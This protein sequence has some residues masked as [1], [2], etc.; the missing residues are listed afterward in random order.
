MFRDSIVPV[1]LVFC[2]PKESYI[3]SLICSPDVALTFKQIER[4]VE[5]KKDV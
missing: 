2:L 4:C 1:F 5:N 3:C